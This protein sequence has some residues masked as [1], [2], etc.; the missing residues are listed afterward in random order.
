MY[1]R[2]TIKSPLLSVKQKLAFLF[3]F[4][5]CFRVSSSYAD[6]SDNQ[7]CCKKRN[8]IKSSSCSLKFISHSS[9]RVKWAAAR[10][11]W[12]VFFVKRSAS[13]HDIK[14]QGKKAQ[15]KR[16]VVERCFG[17]LFFIDH[18]SVKH[19]NEDKPQ[20]KFNFL[21]LSV[22]FVFP[23]FYL[24][25]HKAC[26]DPGNKP[27]MQQTRCCACGVESLTKETSE[28]KLIFNAPLSWAYIHGN[29]EHSNW[30]KEGIISWGKKNTQQKLRNRKAPES[31]IGFE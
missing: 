24:P 30:M 19:F 20:I 16:S 3:L 4:S 21:M 17:C 26:L 18:H 6:V 31:V 10:L 29:Y 1:D 28:P 2:K 14:T 5:S 22:Y 27:V 25:A 7:C 9:N 8:I 12:W 15:Y 11:Q 23:S 13:L